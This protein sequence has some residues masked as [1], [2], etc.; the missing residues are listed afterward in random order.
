[1]NFARHQYKYLVLLGKGEQTQCCRT[2]PIFKAK[3]N[4]AMTNM[5]R[6]CL[7]EGV[8]VICGEF[9]F[10]KCELFY[11]H[12]DCTYCQFKGTICGMSPHRPS[13]SCT[14]VECRHISHRCPV[15][16]TMSEQQRACS[17]L[18]YSYRR[19]FIFCVIS[20]C[21]HAEMN[22]K[23]AGWTARFRKHN[24]EMPFGFK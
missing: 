10:V 12:P 16:G 22:W 18:Y 1:M 21:C 19:L 2:N 6:S 20:A 15:P 13:V 3:H 7:K 17:I 8:I 9:W 11:V 5:W 14:Y 24:L 23:N 4:P